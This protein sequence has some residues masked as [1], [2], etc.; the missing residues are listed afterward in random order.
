MD[1]FFIHH[2]KKGEKMHYFWDFFM[3][4]HKHLKLK[5]Y[6]R[7]LKQTRGKN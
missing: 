6:S 3:L 1:L 4:H 2:E 5:A 7:W